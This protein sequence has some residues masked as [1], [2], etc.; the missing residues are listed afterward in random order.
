MGSEADSRVFCA[1]E[2]R[3]E[4]REI[5]NDHDQGEEIHPH[6]YT[7]PDVH[8]TNADQPN[9]S[10]SAVPDKERVSN[11]QKT[12][13]NSHDWEQ[14]FP[15]YKCLRIDHVERR[16]DKSAPHTRTIPP[17]AAQTFR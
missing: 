11:F 16:T 14:V 12:N 9:L 1:D 4:C 7:D 3:A 8:C 2:I 6:C 5:K 13:N 10:R 17:A 15:S